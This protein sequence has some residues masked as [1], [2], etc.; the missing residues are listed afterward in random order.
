M[1][2]FLPFFNKWEKR[3]DLSLETGGLLVSGE[4][5]GRVTIRQEV[6]FVIRIYKDIKN[7]LVVGQYACCVDI[8]LFIQTLASSA[9]EAPAN[10]FQCKT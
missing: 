4:P 5:L 7:V 2:V 8:S 6:N 9:V 3:L 10:T 1:C